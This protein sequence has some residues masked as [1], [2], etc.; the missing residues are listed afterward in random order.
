MNS[1]TQK[2]KLKEVLGLVK[3]YSR[4]HLIKFFALECL[5]FMS[6][7]VLS[8]DFHG[9]LVTALTFT[10]SLLFDQITKNKLGEDFDYKKVG[11]LCNMGI[12]YISA[13]F[14]VVLCF[15]LAESS[16][17]KRV[18]LI[19]CKIILFIISFFASFSA[20]IEGISN[21]PPQSLPS[22]QEKVNK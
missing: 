9:L 2:W 12:V 10:A 13:I 6:T 16:I 4:V 7:I 17:E 21:L 18:P 5:A 19:T 22:Q 11:D 15:F 14:I 20:L 8:T 3:Q 1:E